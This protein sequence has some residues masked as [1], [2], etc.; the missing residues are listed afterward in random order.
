MRVALWIPC[1]YTP[2][3]KLDNVACNFCKWFVLME[4]VHVNFFD[5]YRITSKEP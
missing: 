2:V 4:I 3:S 1:I 5:R